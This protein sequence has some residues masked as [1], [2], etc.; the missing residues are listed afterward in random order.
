MNR[1]V[2]SSEL[3]PYLDTIAKNEKIP[4]VYILHEREFIR[5]NEPT[6]KIGRTKNPHKRFNNYPKSSELKYFRA[7]TNDLVVENAVRKRFCDIFLHRPDIGAEYFNGNVFDMIDEIER[8]INQLYM[9]STVNA[10]LRFTLASI[11]KPLPK[12]PTI[13]KKLIKQNFKNSF[14]KESPIKKQ[15]IVTTLAKSGTDFFPLP[16]EDFDLSILKNYGLTLDDIEKDDQTETTLVNQKIL[17]LKKA[18][19]T[20]TSNML[21]NVVRC[22]IPSETDKP[23]IKRIVINM[24]YDVLHDD[25]RL[26]NICLSDI[27]RGTIRVLSRVADTD[28]VYWVNYTKNIATKVINKHARHLFL[29]MLEIGMQSLVS[30]SWKDNKCLALSYEND[31]SIILYEEKANLVARNIRSLELSYIP[32]IDVTR[33]MVLIQTRKDKVIEFVH[34]LILDGCDLKTWLEESRRFCYATMQRTISK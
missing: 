7:V 31:R 10:A 22:M 9:A 33:L 25:P 14:N 29:F 24:M 27:S 3:Q 26:H 12:I 11:F 28:K 13:I 4:H 8:V 32:S 16:I 1:L 34:E 19:N 5:C 30:A 21:Y 17:Q 18:K 2:N 15:N 20:F 23:D 6:Y